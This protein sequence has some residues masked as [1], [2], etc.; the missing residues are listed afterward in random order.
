MCEFQDKL[1]G[2]LKHRDQKQANKHLYPGLGLVY[3][4]A[5]RLSEEVFLHYYLRNTH[6]DVCR[7][8]EKERYRQRDAEREREGNR[9][10]K[11]EIC[12]DRMPVFRLVRTGNAHAAQ[13]LAARK[14]VAVGASCCPAWVTQRLEPSRLL[15]RVCVSRKL[16]SG[17]GAGT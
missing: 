9:L 16:K 12:R 8:V 2:D 15:P 6:R 14:L 11:T 10:M 3:S 13:G 17:V 4:K 5:E 1:T 7:E